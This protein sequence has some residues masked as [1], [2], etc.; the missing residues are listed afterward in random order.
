MFP[1]TNPAGAPCT[2]VKLGGSLLDEAD[3]GPRLALRLDACR[4]RRTLLVVGGGAAADIVRGWQRRHGLDDAAAHWLA[5]RAMTLNGHFMAT[6]LPHG[7]VVSD[8]AACSAAWSAG[9]VP[10][11]DVWTLLQ[12]DEQHGRH[13]LPHSWS[14]TS[15]TIAARVARQTGADELLLLKAVSWP[16]DRTLH[17]AV[18]AGVV[19]AWLPRELARAPGLQVRIE[20]FRQG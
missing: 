8:L 11:L 18:R 7:R 9:Q 19:D 20:N 2:V 13:A 6:V 3:L 1:E 14:I 17:E 16:P 12:R 10:I 4:P 5:V 15:D